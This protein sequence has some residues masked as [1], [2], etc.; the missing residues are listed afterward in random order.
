MGFLAEFF[1][2]PSPK[3]IQVYDLKLGI[4][5]RILQF[6]VLCYVA[7]QMVFNA[8]YLEIEVPQAE[9]T[10]ALTSNSEDD[11]KALQESHRRNLSQGLPTY[12]AEA[13]IYGHISETDIVPMDVC[14]SALMDNIISQNSPDF[15]IKTASLEIN[16]TKI[17]VP[18]IEWLADCEGY[19]DNLGVDC[20][21]AEFPE[22]QIAYKRNVGNEFF[23]ITNNT[24]GSCICETS[25][26]TLYTGVEHM[27][28]ALTHGVYSSW[29]NSKLNVKT[30]VRNHENME[31]G[32]DLAV[33]EKGEAINF[34]IAQ[35]LEWADVDLDLRMNE[36]RNKQWL[37]GAEESWMDAM[38]NYPYLRTA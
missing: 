36:G 20:T 37:Q 29:W 24:L 9:M 16:S 27:T 4:L 35:L 15:S 34:T 18:S 10:L 11:Y 28:L 26:G 6:A 12:C 33:F 21:S 14:N 25:I 3:I 19:F 32:S 5:L 2:F 7:L 8:S 13:A 31:R 22:K 38:G 17:P 30:T 23:K 1:S